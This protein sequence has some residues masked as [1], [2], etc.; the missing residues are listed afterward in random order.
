MKW[1]TIGFAA[2]AISM[3]L[4]ASVLAREGARNYLIHNRLR[5]EYD[6][7]IRETERDTTS[8]F[9]IIEEVEFLVNFN[10]ENTFVSVR[11]KPSFVW[12]ENRREGSTDLHHDLDFIF[13]HKFTPRVAL[14]IKNT[15]RYAELPEAIERGTVIR[16]R[17]DF[18]YNSALGT[19]SYQVTPVGRVE[20]SG[21]YDLLRY[22]KSDI[23]RVEDFD[24]FVAG[25]TYRHNIIAE[26]AVSVDTRFETIDY[27]A[28]DRGS[29]SYYFGLGAEHMFSPNVL[30]NARA[31]YQYKDYS[32]SGLS[33]D[34][35]PYVDMSATLVPSP[36]TRVTLGLGYSMLEAD[37][38]PYANQERTR[39]YVGVA[40]DITARVSV[41]VAG[42]YIYAKYEAEDAVFAEAAEA[43]IEFGDGSEDII[44]LS[45]RVTY[46]VNRS[47]WLEAGWQFTTLDSDLRQ[48]FDRNRINIG[49]KT[50]L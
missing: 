42:S 22:D 16:Q 8:S 19:V 49:W 23:A 4:P 10:L 7:N 20:G 27:D 31:G 33:S 39:F 35:A 26:T 32:A 12:W 21:R 45:A 6:D 25:L 46:R 28:V 38:F 34:S 13:N 17:S 50:Q 41:N 14:G 3:A 48:D 36:A 11:Y 18:I 37:I 30:G 43:D 15:F 2:L 9:K 44:Q 29:D 24:M 5:L 1:K 47:N 40:H